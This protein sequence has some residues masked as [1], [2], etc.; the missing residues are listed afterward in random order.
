MRKDIGPTN[1]SY[2]DYLRRNMIG[3]LY[4]NLVVDNLLV[5]LFRSMVE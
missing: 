1:T 5:C 4:E 2:E 3:E